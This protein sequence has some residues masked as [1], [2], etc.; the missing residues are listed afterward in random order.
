MKKATLLITVLVL[1]NSCQTLLHPQNKKLD[2]N[3]TFVV[4]LEKNNYPRGYSDL[5]VDFTNSRQ[6]KE[7]FLNIG[8]PEENFFILHDE[9]G[10]AQVHESF[11]WVKER[12]SE[13]STVIYYIAAHGRYIRGFLRWNV[14]V[15]PRWAE[16]PQENKVMIID[17]CNAG[18]FI[19]KF[20]EESSS[21]ITYG[22]VSPDEIN[23]WGEE[24]EN[25][26]IIGS[27]WVHYF[28]EALDS[29]EADI[30]ND[31]ALSFSEAHQYTNTKVQNYMKEYVFSNTEYL[32]VY[33]NLGYNPMAKESYPNAEMN[34]HL[35]HDLILNTFN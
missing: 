32:S 5:D 27:I 25:L 17:S 12:A 9:I 35:N 28:V 11:A 34:N 31:K 4:L 24:C 8:V 23:W 14:I 15:P 10:E 22:V 19:T 29:P 30:N 33:Q 18:E 26:P 21:G 13:N 16:L 6:M 7:L 3:N 1:F 20:D 2:P